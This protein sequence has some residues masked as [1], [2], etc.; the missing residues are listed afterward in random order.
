MNFSTK[1]CNKCGNIKS[2]DSFHKRKSS[3]DG[4]EYCCKECKKTY[5][6]QYKTNNVELIQEYISNNK[7]KI[8]SIAKK[9]YIK[10]KQKINEYH[11]EHYE[12]YNY[13]KQYAVKNRLK[14]NEY[15]KIKYNTDL[16]AK[17]KSNISNRIRAALKSINIKKDN[18]TINLLGC[19]I[20]FY[21]QYLEQQFKPDM[22][23]E[24][25]GILWEIDHIKPCAAFD[26][27]DSKQQYEC[28][29]YLNT[30]PLYYS[31]NRSKRD[32]F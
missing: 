27:T 24:N 16:Q 5:D 19:N 6:K 18:K 23:W 14:I 20:E 30:Q 8:S 7:E 4:Y 13:Q 12:K 1:K 32:K 15:N 25:H 31:D 21:K 28:F 10:N 26:L 9:Y 22:T 29:H 11:K 17:L 3:I 2:L